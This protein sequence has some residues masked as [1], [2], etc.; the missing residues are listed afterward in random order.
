VQR[1]WDLLG[2]LKEL[3]ALAF[4]KVQ[5]GIVELYELEFI[6]LKERVVEG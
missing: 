5:G 3:V 1:A 6:L 4:N 2:T